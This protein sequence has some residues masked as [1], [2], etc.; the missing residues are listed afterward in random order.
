MVSTT[1]VASDARICSL[2]WSRFWRFDRVTSSCWPRDVVHQVRD[3]RLDLCFA[4]DEVHVG[5]HTVEQPSARAQDCWDEVQADLVD[6]AIV[7]ELLRNARPAGY[8]DVLRAGCLSRHL[9][10]GGSDRS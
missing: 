7:Q 1:R 2:P 8:V 9:Q 10:S 4:R 3:R 5:V 6:Q